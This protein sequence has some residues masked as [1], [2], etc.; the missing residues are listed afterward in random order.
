[1]DQYLSFWEPIYPQRWTQASSLNRVTVMSILPAWPHEGASSQNSVFLDIL[2]LDDG[3]TTLSRNVG[4]WL[5]SDVASCHRRT[6]TS[7]TPV[8]KPKNSQIQSC[9]TICHRVC[10]PHLSSI[11]I[12]II[13]WV[14]DQI[15]MCQSL[16]CCVF[17]GAQTFFLLSIYTDLSYHFFPPMCLNN[18]TLLAQ[19]FPVLSQNSRFPSLLSHNFIYEYCHMD[20]TSNLHLVLNRPLS[21]LTSITFVQV[22]ALQ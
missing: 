5:P 10:E 8:Q 2:T 15:Y 1:M 3:T 12:M 11:I 4:N 17:I 21:I 19:T 9:F 14:V 20:Y 18:D 7:A 13:G 6:E 22:K 16:W